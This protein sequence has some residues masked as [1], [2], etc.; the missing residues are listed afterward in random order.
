[1]PFYFFDTSCVVKR[2]CAEAGTN[3][4]DEIYDAPD[5]GI[6]ISNLTYTEVLSALN[7]KKQEGLLSQV[8]FDEAIGK[9]FFDYQ[10]KYLVID[11]DKDIRISAGE[12]IMRHNL[13]SGDSIQLATALHDEDFDLIFVSSD[14]NL[15]KAADSEGLEVLNP[16]K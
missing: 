11:L 3:K 5:N 1:M 4:I 7:R 15:C 13:R 16:E 10:S 2:Y 8:A 6:I 9:F 14:Q 12:L